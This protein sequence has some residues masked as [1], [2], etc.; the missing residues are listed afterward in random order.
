MSKFTICLQFSRTKRAKAYLINYILQER[1][2]VILFFVV[3]HGWCHLII[4]FPFVMQNDWK[5]QNF[6]RLYY[7]HFTAFRNELNFGILLILWCSFK[8]WWNFCP[9]LSRS[10]FHS[11]GDRSIVSILKVY[12]LNDKGVHDLENRLII[13]KLLQGLLPPAPPSPRLLRLWEVINRKIFTDLRFVLRYPC[14]CRDFV[15]QFI[16]MVYT[17]NTIL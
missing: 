17:N 6:E 1:V 14:K 12:Y 8:L 10:K 11:K 4:N 15:N 9:D 13:S 2:W 5:T 3:C 7:P 16:P